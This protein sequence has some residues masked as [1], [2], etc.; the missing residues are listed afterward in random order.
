MYPSNLQ[1]FLVDVVK[2]IESEDKDK[3]VVNLTRFYLEMVGQLFHRCRNWR[4]LETH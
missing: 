2:T 1:L 4:L 3:I